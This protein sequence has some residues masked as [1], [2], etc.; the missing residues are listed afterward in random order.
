MNDALPPHSTEA[1]H[2]VLGCILQKP[3]DSM[4][5]CQSK[6]VGPADFYDIRNA[7]IFNAL[8]AMVEDQKP[9]DTLTVFQQLKNEGVAETVGGIAHLSALLDAAPSPENVGYWLEILKEKSTYRKIIRIC[10]EHQAKAA[11]NLSNPE[12]LLTKFEEAVSAIRGDFGH[13]SRIVQ[14]KDAVRRLTDD[15]QARFNLQGRLSGVGTGLH[16]L[17]KI[18]NGLQFGEM[19]IIG[20]RPSAGKT[21]IACTVIEQAC[22]REGVPTAVVTL[23][24]PEKALLR[25]LCA[26]WGHL[27]SQSLRSGNLNQGDFT[28]IAAFNKLV[29]QAPLYFVDGVSG[30]T[31]GQIASDIRRLVK[32]HGV[33]LVVIDYLQKIKPSAS[34]EKRTYEVGA[35]SQAVKGLA[36]ST[37]VAMLCLAQLNREPDK[38]NEKGRMPR[39]SD[40]ADSAQIERDG[41]M[42]GLLH[43]TKSE[44][45]PKGENAKL[46]IAKQ[47]DGEVGIVD[48]QFVPRFCTFKC[49]SPI[50]D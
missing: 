38:G 26:S 46:L 29:S 25:R 37:G 13:V 1:E 31:I 11:G 47:R 20:A 19:A 50:E 15:L 44:Q 18:T 21:A 12:E 27:D 40:L 42:I 22:L 24:M 5:A 4:E 8:V 32:R 43:R 7:A 2:G 36:D 28:K 49:A 9:I 10:S 14:P 39:L 34:H 41:D 23:E 35:V 30:M 33:K 17:D 16:G 48:L 3:L 45:D 6:A